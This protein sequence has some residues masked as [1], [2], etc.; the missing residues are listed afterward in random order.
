MANNE[1]LPPSTLRQLLAYNSETG[2]LTWRWRDRA[3]F[4]SDLEQK[5]WNTRYAGKP[6][7]ATKCPDKGY[8]RGKIFN[9]MFS[10]H[11]LA[12]A[13]HYGELPSHCIDH[14]NG[15]RS[16]NRIV[17]LRDVPPALNSRNAKIPTN[18]KSGCVGVAWSK[19]NKRWISY[20]STDDG[21]VHIGSFREY[22]EAVAAR[23]N[24]EHK[25]N[26]H[27]NHGARC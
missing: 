15:D 17:N 20:I 6:A 14:I 27:Q 1:L 21:R 9:K 7:L 23:R 22:N 3:F 16:D 25:N 4:G 11:R 2:Q 19:K 8:L 10:A 5:R 24:L 18:N 12:W 13:I 26:Y